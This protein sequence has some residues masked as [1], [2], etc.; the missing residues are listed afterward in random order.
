MKI[1]V[2]MA[3]NILRERESLW[4]LDSIFS[5][6]YITRLSAEG[7]WVEGRLN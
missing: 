3:I 2:A 7:S 5:Q 4:S 6:K 1:T